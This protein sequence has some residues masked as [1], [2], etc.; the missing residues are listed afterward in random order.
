MGRTVVDKTGLAGN[1]DF[2]VTY[3]PDQ[4]PNLNGAPAPIDPNGPSL[5]TALQEQLGLKLESHRGPVTMFIV[6]K[7]SQPTPD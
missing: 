6:D 2:E 3:T 1:Y 4:I 5:S 7:V